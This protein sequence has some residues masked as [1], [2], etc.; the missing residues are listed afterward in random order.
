MKPDYDR[1]LNIVPSFEDAHLLQRWIWTQ[2][3]AAEGSVAI[4]PSKVEQGITY[5]L[6]FGEDVAA[7]C[8]GQ[9]T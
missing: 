3:E 7:L 1:A 2:E 9:G 6:C 8:S 4:N 5:R